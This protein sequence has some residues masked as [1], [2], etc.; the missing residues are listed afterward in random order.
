MSVTKENSKA[1]PESEPTV[2]ISGRMRWVV[3]VFIAVLLAP[4]LLTVTGKHGAVLKLVQPRLETAVHYKGISSH[5]WAPVEIVDVQVKDLSV[6][7]GSDGAEPIP[8]ATAVSVSS[9]QPLWRLVLSGGNGAE[10]IVRQPVVNVAV[11]DGRTNVEDTLER[12][13]GSND[14]SGKRS[15]VSA[16]IEDGTIRFLS[17]DVAAEPESRPAYTSITGIF[18][19]LST[20]NQTLS[21]P[22]LSLIANVGTLKDQRNQSTGNGRSNTQVAATLD[23][24]SADY[25]LLPFSEEQ[26]ADLHS[27]GN[28]PDLEISLGPSDGHG[29][30]QL[31]LEARRL[32]MPQLQGLLQRWL[33][34]SAFRGEISCRIQGHVIGGELI[35]GIA[36]RF[37]VLGDGIRWRKADWAIG[38]SL[39]LNRVTAQGAIALAEDGILVN[40]LQISSSILQLVG[41]GEVRKLLHD[42]VQALQQSAASRTRAEQQVIAEA[43]AATAGQVKATGSVNLAAIAQMLPRT[44]SLERGVE[45]QS[46]AVR[47]SARIQN[48]P[49]LASDPLSTVPASTAFRWQVAAQSSPVE[50]TRD[51]RRILIDSPCRLDVLGKLDIHGVGIDSVSLQGSFGKISAEP[52]DSGYEVSGTIN[53]ERLWDDFRDLLDIPR[54]GLRGDVNVFTRVEPIKDGIQLSRLSLKSSGLQLSSQ[55]LNVYKSRAALRMCEG[56]FELLGDS[57]AVKSLIAPWYSATWLADQSTVSAQLIA[58]PRQ[59]ISA[60]V[61]VKPRNSVR[62]ASL[63][64]TISASNVESVPLLIDEGRADASLV[65]DQRTGDFLVEKCVIELPGVQAVLKGTMG[66]REGLLQVNLRADTKYDL[67]VLSQR[68]IDPSG[69]I[70]LSGRGR[71]QFVLGGAPSLITPADLQRHRRSSLAGGGSVNAEDAVQMLHATGKVV[72]TAGRLHGISVGA[73]TVAAELKNGLLRSEPVQCTLGDGELNMMPQWDL[74]ANQLQLAAGSRISNIR[75]TPE[76]CREWIGFVAPLLAESTDV[77]G[78]CSARVHQ[79][80]Y[81]LDHPEDSTIQVVLTVHR[82]SASPGASLAPLV[83]VLNAV[84]KTDVSNRQLEFPLQDI[85][86]QLS[87]GMIVHD[88]LEMSLAGY[89]VR[90]AGGVGLDRRVDLV[91]DIPFEKSANIQTG[92]SIRIAVG[93]TV[94]RPQ[95]DTVGL[96]QSLGRQQL[97]GRINGQLNN[98]LKELFDKL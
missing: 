60:N 61:V 76:L 38:E 79:F 20:L 30:Q 44:L 74:N 29:M 27:S 33:P 40:D 28:E 26:L 95:L 64:R 10:F 53:A 58:D 43:Q 7:L 52:L 90:S 80:L 66:I 22:E 46:G 98:G 72:W 63:Y 81:L 45:A 19:R 13:F 12:L 23:E 86:V 77:D 48:D 75:L 89:N 70:A 56:S 87:N 36:G 18:G 31:M 8:L 71:E 73:G 59:Q 11:H 47:F 85:P 83:Q 17:P 35:Q 3:F 97:E 55:L 16:T 9:V 78:T 84:G 14:T 4:T 68:V 92:R 34:D 49:Q 32:Q 93:G 6:E 50:A 41:N 15:A 62:P 94:D 57:P 39:N 91:F 21:L 67:D 96:L 65:A 5:W 69:T 37:H 88:G 25:P 51:G 82:G 54:P 42:P 2:S 1:D 24:L